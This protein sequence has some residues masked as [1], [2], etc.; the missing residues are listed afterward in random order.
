MRFRATHICIYEMPGAVFALGMKISKSTYE[1]KFQINFEVNHIK[2]RNMHI[3][4]YICSPAFSFACCNWAIHYY[5]QGQSPAV[6][7]INTSIFLV[8]LSNESIDIEY[9]FSIIAK[10][11]IHGLSPITQHTFTNN[12][13]ISGFP[14]LVRKETLD[15]DYC[16]DGLIHICC[17]MKVVNLP[18][19]L[20]MFCSGGLK[21]HVENLWKRGEEFDVTFDV[22]GK[23][24]SAHRLI[25]AARSPVFKA[26]LF[27]QMVEANMDYIR[28]EDMKPEVFEALIRFM[29]TDRLT[30]FPFSDACSKLS[31]EFLEELFVASDRYALDKLKTMCEKRLAG[32][33][34]VDTIVPTLILADQHNSAWLKEKCFEFAS[35][36]N[37]FMQFALIN[38]YLQALQDVPSLFNELREN[39][40]NM[41]SV[42]NMPPKKQRTD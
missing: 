30:N 14:N 25:L 39:I 19:E 21:E 10:T 7:E 17:Y 42:G 8:L 34:S 31:N 35:D 27:G 9:F 2:S 36:P 29:Y 26:E 4:H 40:N 20:H 23:R 13:H 5:P 41:L 38:G 12:D 6:Q 18:K 16:I 15:V 1:V 3:G 37:N 24:I 11:G 22:E 28:I 32:K 33:L